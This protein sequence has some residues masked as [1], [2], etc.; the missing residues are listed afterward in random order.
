MIAEATMRSQNQC[1]I[2]EGDIAQQRTDTVIRVWSIHETGPQNNKVES[3]EKIVNQQISSSLGN[4]LFNRSENSQ[5]LVPPETNSTPRLNSAFLVLG[6]F[7]QSLIVRLMNSHVCLDFLSGSLFSNKLGYATREADDNLHK[8]SKVR[9]KTLS[10]K[11]HAPP[12]ND[13]SK[14]HP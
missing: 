2:D 4:Q 9:I 8:V 7:A 12:Q 13:P 5:C 1:L 10:P 14:P 6:T 11:P 3:I